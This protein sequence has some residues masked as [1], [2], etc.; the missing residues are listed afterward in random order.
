VAIPACNSAGDSEEESG[1]CGWRSVWGRAIARAVVEAK[2]RM[3]IEYCI[4]IARKSEK[5]GSVGLK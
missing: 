5:D 1:D 4:L 3:L 2:A